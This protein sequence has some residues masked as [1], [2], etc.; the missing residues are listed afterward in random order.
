MIDFNKLTEEEQLKQIEY[1]KN[2]FLKVK[3]PSEEFKL[4]AI[5]KNIYVLELI[6]NPSEKLQL[7]AI[8]KSPMN[9][10]YIKNPIEKVKL[11]AVRYHSDWISYIKKEE[12]SEA[13]QIEVVKSLHCKRF[14][15]S[16]NESFV[17][18]FIDNDKAL[19][20]YEKLKKVRSII[21]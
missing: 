3:S 6:E 13:I 16:Y 21:K 18:V 5:K 14:A 8:N 10:A 1:D 19:E 11:K 20:L 12:R 4:K 17:K 2:Y 7:Y 9:I 15:H